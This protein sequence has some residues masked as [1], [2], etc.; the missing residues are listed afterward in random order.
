VLVH[1]VLTAIP[2][3]LLIALKVPKWFI[4]AIDKIR[5]GFLWKGRKFSEWWLLLSSLGESHK[6]F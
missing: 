6:A 3:Y 4:H 2:I 1:F 5:I